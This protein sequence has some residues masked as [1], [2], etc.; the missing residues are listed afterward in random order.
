MGKKPPPSNK[1]KSPEQ[2]QEYTKKRDFEKTTEPVGDLPEVSG[3]SFVVHRHHATRL[4]YDLRLEEDGVLKSWAV[5]KGMP[6]RPGIK[7][8]AVQT[9]DHPLE[10]LT[11]NGAIPKGEYGAGNM[12]VYATGK[13]EYTKKK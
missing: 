9:E 1:Y 5:P 10:Y 13:Y 12:W 2:L 11:F 8:L 3:N 4:H 7:R 6:Q